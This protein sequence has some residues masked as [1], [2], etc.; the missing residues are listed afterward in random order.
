MQS[1]NRGSTVITVCHKLG[2]SD[3]E[4]SNSTVSVLN[5]PLNDDQLMPLLGQTLQGFPSFCFR[6][7][8]HGDIISSNL[9]IVI[10]AQCTILMLYH[11]FLIIH[12]LFRSGL[13][14]IS[15]VRHVHLGEV[16]TPRSGL[17]F[18]F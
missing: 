18:L 5:L 15:I 10:V 11:L 2:F 8:R 16:D 12:K 6:L 1:R 7:I 9:F 17:I 13:A 3:S 14:S 4:W